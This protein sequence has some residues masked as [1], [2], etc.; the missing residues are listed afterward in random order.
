VVQVTGARLG[1]GGQLGGVGRAG[2]EGLDGGDR[3]AGGVGE[4]DADGAGPG[5]GDGGADADRAGGV[6]GDPGPGER[7]LDARTVPVAGP[8]T[9][10]A[11]AVVGT[12]FALP[13]ITAAGERGGVDGG[14]EEGGVDGVAGGLVVQVGGQG[15]VGVGGVV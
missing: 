11:V 2:G 7:Q 4:V 14:V 3:G 10:A 15:D 13:G 9:V 5:G 6:K 8:M 12:V 1:G